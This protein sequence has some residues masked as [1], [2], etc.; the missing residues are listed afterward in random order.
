MRVTPCAGLTIIGSAIQSLFQSS[1]WYETCCSSV[2]W[3]TSVGKGYLVVHD[4][5]YIPYIYMNRWLRM[6]RTDVPSERNAAHI[7]PLRVCSTW[8]IR[9]C[10]FTSH[11]HHTLGTY[12]IYT[13]LLSNA[14]VSIAFKYGPRHT[15]H[16]LLISNP[17][18]GW[19]AFSEAYDNQSLFCLLKWIILQQCIMVHGCGI[20]FSRWL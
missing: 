19:Q 16:C 14:T 6:Q 10:I 9:A 13:K 20:R 11:L 1:S 15:T 7:Y 2:S 5:V 17:V 18:Q 12:D 8:K 3:C 4:E